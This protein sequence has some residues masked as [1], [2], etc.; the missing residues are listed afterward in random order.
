MTN[1]T[2]LAEEP[3]DLLRRRIVS[4]F[5]RRQ[6]NLVDLEV[7]ASY[8][9]YYKRACKALHLGISGTE[10][11]SLSIQAHEDLLEMVDRF[12]LHNSQPV[13]KVNNSINF[14]FRLWLT[15]RIQEADFS[16][17]AKTFQWDD[18]SKI[19]EFLARNFPEPRSH[20]TDPGI[21]LESNFTAVN[22][23]RMCGIRVE[24]TYQLEDHLKYDIE[25]RTV[26]IYSL[27]QCLRD[28]LD[29]LVLVSREGPK[30]RANMI[31]KF[32]NSPAWSRRRDSA[33]FE[34]TLPKLEYCYG[35]LSPPIS[36][37]STP[38]NS[39]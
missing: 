6:E 22:L 26:S 28:H 27:S 36:A 15:I 32:I 8:F 18:T 31:A 17:A 25:N 24:W 37:S 7:Y 5:W 39:S 30:S 3:S 19:H 2:S 9:Y 4:H 10:F 14:L 13:R 12:P 20:S 34:Y 21:L 1:R 16:P 11:D 29:W 38:R 33:F 35:K 23:Y